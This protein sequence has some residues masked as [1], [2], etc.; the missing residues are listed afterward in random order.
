MSQKRPVYPNNETQKR[1]D[2]EKEARVK[3]LL[4]ESSDKKEGVR[5]KGE[6]ERKR[7]L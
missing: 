4:G 7:K 1:K 2:W 3:E 5:K 6:I